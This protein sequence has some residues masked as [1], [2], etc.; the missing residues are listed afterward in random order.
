M[1][2]YEAFCELAWDTVPVTLGT[3]VQL[4][5]MEQPRGVWWGRRIVSRGGDEAG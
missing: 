3:R 2:G 4:P 1:G 5:V